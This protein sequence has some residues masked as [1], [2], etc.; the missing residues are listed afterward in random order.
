[1][2]AFSNFENAAVMMSPRSSSLPRNVDIFFVF[3]SKSRTKKG[4]E[5]DACC[6]CFLK[7]KCTQRRRKQRPK[8]ANKVNAATVFN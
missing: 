7:A 3:S 6:C 4:T 5:G 1:M 8:R 2:T